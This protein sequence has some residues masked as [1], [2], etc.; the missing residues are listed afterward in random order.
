MKLPINI[1]ILDKQ[2]D[3]HSYYKEAS[4]LLNLSRVDQ[5]IETF[6]LTILEAMSYGIPC[7]VP[8]IGGPAELIV[9]DNE[10]YLISSYEINKVALLIENLSNDK[11]KCMKLSYNTNIKLSIFN[12]KNFGK[13]IIRV[14]NE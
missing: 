6:G 14:L 4:L 10:G 1:T 7:I 9:D 3:L 5:W 11:D 8:P 2:K 13:D 12:L